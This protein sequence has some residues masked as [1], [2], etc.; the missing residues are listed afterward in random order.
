MKSAE[1]YTPPAQRVWLHRITSL[2]VFAVMAWRVFG[3]TG[4]AWRSVRYLAVQA[5]ALGFI[6]LS[7]D[8]FQ[9]P[10]S[11]R[12]VSYRTVAWILML[13]PIAIWMAA[14]TFSLIFP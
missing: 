14:A 5:I 7:N 2:L 9:D 13:F 10:V 1:Y 6:W 8:Y 4:F 12:I 11:K 3:G